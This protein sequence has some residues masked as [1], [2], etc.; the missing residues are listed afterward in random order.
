M[1]SRKFDKKLMLNKMTVTQLDHL[2]LRKV[3]GR[4]ACYPTFLVCPTKE[5]ACT[6]LCGTIKPTEEQYCT[7]LCQPTYAS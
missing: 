1:K 3:Q 2:E 4:A 5:M 6:L 7:F